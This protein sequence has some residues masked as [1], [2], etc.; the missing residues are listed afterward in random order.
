MVRELDSKAIQSVYQTFKEE[1]TLILLKLLSEVA[2]IAEERTSQCNLLHHF[3]LMISWSSLASSAESYPWAQKHCL[4]L[5]K[6]DLADAIAQCL[7]C[8]WHRLILSPSYG[9]IPQR[10]FLD[11]WWQ[12]DYIQFSSVAHSCRLFAIPWI[13]ARQASLS[14]TN[15]QSSLKLLSIESVMPSSH[16]ILYITLSD[17]PCAIP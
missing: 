17:F 5:T 6:F 8:Q 10:D 14:I 7:I 9:V 12:L 16:L 11:A 2:E 13:P 4:S 15:S 3:G 1:L